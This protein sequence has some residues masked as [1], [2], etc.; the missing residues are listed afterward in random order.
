MREGDD[1]RV[2]PYRRRRAVLGNRSC[3][4]CGA[5]LR[6]SNN[7]ANCDCCNKQARRKHAVME[8]H[9]VRVIDNK[10][11]RKLRRDNDGPD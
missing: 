9:K 10:F 2:T 5:K 8:L 7:Y 11:T 6:R 1:I 3:D 4:T